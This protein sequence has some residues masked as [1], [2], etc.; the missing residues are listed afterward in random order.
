VADAFL[1]ALRADWR[2]LP[3]KADALEAEFKRRRQRARLS[4][5]V[6]AMGVVMVAVGLVALAA[7]ALQQRD[8]AQTIAAV[9]FAA[10]LPLLVLGLV[11]QSRSMKSAASLNPEGMLRFMR[12]QAIYSRRRLWGA[13]ACAAILTTAV[14][15]LAVAVVLD[16]TSVASGLFSISLWLPT[17]LLVWLWQHS[18][19]ARLTQEIERCEQ[20]IAEF[21]GD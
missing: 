18:R 12:Q 20:M 9:A 21:K 6:T 17:A 8:I 5:T 19:S 16:V 4:L 11:E 3:A 2:A 1:D 13:R 14:V 7:L 15:A 10:A